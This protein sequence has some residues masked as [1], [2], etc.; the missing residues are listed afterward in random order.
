PTRRSSD[1]MCLV[2]ID[3]IGLQP[4]QRSFHRFFHVAGLKSLSSRSHI[5]SQLGGKDHVVAAAPLTE[6][7]PK[8]GFGLPTLV[9]LCPF[10]IGIGRVDKIK[11]R[12]Q[13][14]VEDPEGFAF[15]QGPSKYVSAKGKR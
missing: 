11:S 8:D 5:S 4:L 3:V 15:V 12:V 7:V 10:R 1:L 9:A 14:G 2:Q 6:P 13:E